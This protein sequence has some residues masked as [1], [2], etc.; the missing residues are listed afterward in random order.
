[1]SFSTGLL[2]AAEHL[3]Q[4]CRRKGRLI[5]TAESCTGGLIAGVLTAVPGSS[6]VVDCGFVTYSND[7]KAKMIGVPEATIRQHGAVSADVAVA[8]AQGAIAQSRAHLAIAVT[9][10][11]GPGGGS[12]MKPVGLVWLATAARDGHVRTR[13]LRLGDIG[14]EEVRLATVGEALAMLQ[15]LADRDP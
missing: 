10:V 4:T 1:M 7:A 13:E 14:R 12:P 8:M 5:A 2:N 3:L 15:E 6:D 11:A 9:G